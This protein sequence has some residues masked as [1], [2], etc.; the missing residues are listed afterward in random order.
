MN[1][2]IDPDLLVETSCNDPDFHYVLHIAH[3]QWHGIRSAT[4]SMPGQKLLISADDKITTAE[5]NTIYETIEERRIKKVVFQ[6]YSHN[7]DELLVFLRSKCA[8]TVKFYAITHVTTTQFV[9]LFE[10]DMIRLLQNRLQRGLIERLGSVKPNFSCYVTEVCSPTIINFMPIIHESFAMDQDE[11]PS[12]FVPLDTDWRKNLYTNVTAALMCTGADHVKTANFPIN[13]QD[14]INTSKLRLTGFLT[15]E[16]LFCEYA[17]SS[18]LLLSTLAECQP[19][20][21]LE[22]F[23]VGTPAMT[24]DLGI[25]EFANDPL[26]RLCSTQHLDDPYSLSLDVEKLL[27]ITIN[28]SSEISDMLNDHKSRRLRIATNNLKE[29]LQI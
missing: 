1:C 5:K 23:A 10:I 6:G 24:R 20:T 14:I 8:L 22:A 27:S 26:M 16:E 28:N 13:L 7:A 2:I 17:K 19:M 25:S 9:H 12:I 15:G 18:I 29:F 3:S 11:N 4:A 21:Q